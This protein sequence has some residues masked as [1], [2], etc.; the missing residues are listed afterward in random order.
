MIVFIISL[1]EVKMVS[2][3]R[4]TVIHL[5][6]ASTLYLSCI[7]DQQPRSCGTV[8]ETLGASEGVLDSFTPGTDYSV[9]SRFLLLSTNYRVSLLRLGVQLLYTVVSQ[10]NVVELSLVVL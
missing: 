4:S 8:K 2:L 5:L 6:F 1:V 3:P 7:C 10:L 9:V